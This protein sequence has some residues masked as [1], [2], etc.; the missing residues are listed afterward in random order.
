MEILSPKKVIVTDLVPAA[1]KS[2]KKN[3]ARYQKTGKKIPVSFVVGNLCDPLGDNKA[4]IIYANIPNIPIKSDR[5]NQLLDGITA[6][7]FFDLGLVNG[8]PEKINKHL[9][10]L[11][12]KF[13]QQA[14]DHLTQNGIV[15]INLGARF[16]IKII[17]QLF[18]MAGYD[19]DV[20]YFGFKKQTEIKDTIPGYSQNEKNGIIFTYYPYKQAIKLLKNKHIKNVENLIKTLKPLR[21]SATEALKRSRKGEDMGHIVT[22]LE[23]R[24]RK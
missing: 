18:D 16:P 8:V 12:Y 10:A 2:A 22:L 1:I 9:L 20:L 5:K 11:Q 21:I 4:D 19:Y 7:T 15:V 13:L 14:K 6:S 3:V 23:A 17:D 24:L